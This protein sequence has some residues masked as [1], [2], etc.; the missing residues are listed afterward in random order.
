MKRIGGHIAHLM[1][2]R[3]LLPETEVG[4]VGECVGVLALCR[5]LF[6]RAIF[7]KIKINKLLLGME[8]AFG[9]VL[10]EVEQHAE[11]QV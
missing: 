4:E 6:P 2:C 1:I 11:T 7:T 9:P 10:G 8:L 5:P 3:Y